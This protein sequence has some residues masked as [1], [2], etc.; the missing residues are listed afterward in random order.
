MGFHAAPRYTKDLDLLITVQAP[1][2]QRLFQC[3]TDFGAPVAI[4]TPEELLE[5]DFVF[6]F[7]VPPWRVDVL[8][9]IPGVDFEAAY[10]ARVALPLGDYTATCIDREWLIRA[11]RASGRPQDLLDLESLG[12]I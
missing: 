12:E 4:I 2:N 5:K 8:T 10:A 1:D 3:L 11:K 6:H 9:S 7:G